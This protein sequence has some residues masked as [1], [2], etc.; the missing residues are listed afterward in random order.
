MTIGVTPD[1][2]PVNRAW[3]NSPMG[4]KAR[5]YGVAM[6]VLG[7]RIKNG[8]TRQEDLIVL[9]PYLESD[10]RQ[11]TALDE[12]NAG[13]FRAYANAASGPLSLLYVAQSKEEIIEG[14]AFFNPERP[15]YRYLQGKIP[16]E[17]L[18]LYG[19]FVRA[20]NVHRGEDGKHFRKYRGMGKLLCAVL[21]QASK[22]SKLG[23]GKDS[24]SLLAAGVTTGNAFFE[25]IGMKGLSRTEYYFDASNGNNF[26]VRIHKEYK[27]LSAV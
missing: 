19:L 25:A 26:L 14:L 22:E 10:H 3:L 23:E 7:V 12:E 9:R 24:G 13:N 5:A 27:F 16:K 21:T 15:D 20:H 6:P 4:R 11:L 17:T 1:S 18:T 8:L 2:F